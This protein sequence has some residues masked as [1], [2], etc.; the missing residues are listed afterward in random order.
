MKFRS[1]VLRAVGMAALSA[2]L[3]SCGG[4]NGLVPFVPARIL[5]F[6]DEASVITASGR[7]YTINALNADGSIDCVSNPI[8]IQALAS[9]YGMVFPQCVGT[10]N[11]PNPASLILAQPGAT[12][13]GTSDADLAQ[14]ITLQ[15]QQPVSDGGG[16]SSSDLVTVYIGVN[17]VVAAFQSYQA[18]ASPSDAQAQVEQAG[19]AVATQLMR[20]ADAGGKV[21]V[22]TVPDVGAT[23]FGRSLDLASAAEL[24]YLTVRLNNEML[25]TLSNAGYNDG[26]KIGLI[27]INT[28]LISVV[29]NPLPYG[30]VDV[31]NAACVPLDPLL[32]T[33][34]TLQTNPDGTSAGAFTWL[35]A[36]ALQLSPGGHKQLGNVASSRAHN[37]PF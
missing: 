4:G 35:W 25:L 6:G 22:A 17:D 8:W 20:I 24:S 5:A 7:K 19:V 3:G 31:T 9:S 1:T 14:Q 2:L 28:Y 21:I 10:S 11:D 23:P 27:E 33:T 36:S 37:Q 26:R 12:A 18:G 32:C 13:A 16:I 30:Y 29:A 34:D 15:L